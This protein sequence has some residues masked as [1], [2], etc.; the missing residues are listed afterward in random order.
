MK[1]E[2]PEDILE[3]MIAQ[4][5]RETPIE[6]CGILGGT[7]GKVSRLYEMTNAEASCE[8][9]T[10]VPEEQFK[11]VKEMR[12]DGIS[13]QAVYHSHPETPARPSEEDIRLAVMP[14]ATY[15]I[16][17]LVD[18]KGPDVKAFQIE[19]GVVTTVPIEITK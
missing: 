15:V 12:A 16:L 19:D 7:E 6:A 4:A 5:I 1:L 10:M 2:I 13:M 9:F 14:G 18:E 17:S 3:Q 11:V 8:H